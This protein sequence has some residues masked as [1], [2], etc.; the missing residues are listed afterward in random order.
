MLKC[1]YTEKLCSKL[2]QCEHYQKFRAYCL[3]VLALSNDNLEKTIA[4]AVA[5]CLVC[6]VLV[7]FAAVALK[8]LQVSNKE[9]DMKKN[10]LDV[11]GLLQAISL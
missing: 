7:A 4:I 11:A 2:E 1:Q 6:A 9:L 5:L 8:P 3:K 10:I